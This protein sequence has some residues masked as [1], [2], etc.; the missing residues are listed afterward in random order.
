MQ[1]PEGL[2]LPIDLWF[3]RSPLPSPWPL[4]FDGIFGR[5]EIIFPY[6]QCYR[7]TTN[8]VTNMEIYKC[9]FPKYVHAFLLRYFHSFWESQDRIHLCKRS[10]KVL[11]PSW[12]NPNIIDPYT[13]YNSRNDF[14]IVTRMFRISENILPIHVDHQYFCKSLADACV[15]ALSELC[16]YW[17]RFTFASSSFWGSGVSQRSGRKFSGSS[18]DFGSRAV[19]SGEHPINVSFGSFIPSTTWGDVRRLKT[20]KLVY[21]R[22]VSRNA[23]SMRSLDLFSR[24]VD[25]VGISMH[26]EGSIRT[27]LLDLRRPQLANPKYNMQ[28]LC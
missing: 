16:W 13:I 10:S 27:S 5:T 6:S 19:R 4:I 18:H 11:S 28:K 1:P 26:E 21:K 20:R 3:F 7:S 17:T 22:A 25:K 15:L 23:A 9:R 12:F 24:S 14:H 8:C 2:L